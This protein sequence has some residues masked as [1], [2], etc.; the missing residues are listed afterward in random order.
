MRAWVM[1]GLCLLGL[2]GVTLEM[3]CYT[4]YEVR[5]T[6]NARWVPAYRGAFGRWHRGHWRCV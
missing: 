5:P 6:C 4:E 2:A 3:G 1:T